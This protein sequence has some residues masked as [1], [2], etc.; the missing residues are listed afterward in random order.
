[1]AIQYKKII[2]EIM[3]PEAKEHGFDIGKIASGGFYKRTLINYEK[4]IDDL[5]VQGFDI[6]YE[7]VGKNE[8]VLR[9][10][11]LNETI[12]FEKDNQDSFRSA[13]TEFA[14]IMREKGYKLFE[15]DEKK[16]RFHSFE[17]GYLLN[18]YKDLSRKFYNE[19]NID[20]TADIMD[21]LG[22]VVAHVDAERN[23]DF[24]EIKDELIKITAFYATTLLECEGTKM[25]YENRG[26]DYFAIVQGKTGAINTLK[27]IL[28]LW[29]DGDEKQ[30]IYHSCLVALSKDRFES[31]GLSLHA[32]STKTEDRC[33]F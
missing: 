19:N 25:L 2:K 23:K 9:A 27:T 33:V 14:L 30:F 24:S 31:L 32:S 6:E 16:P 15:E 13:I 26:I 20:N 3:G 17:H 4:K 29:S 18:N 5:Y 10:A 28:R 12:A 22:I 8:L 11:G 21:K 7:F 1:M